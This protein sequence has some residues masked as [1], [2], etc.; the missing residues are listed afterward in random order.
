MA[1][2]SW[3]N[4]ETGTRRAMQLIGFDTESGVMGF[5]GLSK[6]IETLKQPDTLAFDRRSY[7]PLGICVIRAKWLPRTPRESW[8]SGR[9]NHG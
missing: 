1:Q 3:R 4:P 2:S 5:P 9:S 7:G 8:D 6:L